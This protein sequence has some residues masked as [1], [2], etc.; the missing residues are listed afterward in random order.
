MDKPQNDG[1]SKRMGVERGQ[2]QYK[3][4]S[5]NAPARHNTSVLLLLALEAGY[6]HL[7]G[8]LGGCQIA[9]EHRA[10]EVRELLI[11]RESLEEL[12]PED[13]NG[14]YRRLNLAVRVPRDGEPKLSADVD[15]TFSKTAESY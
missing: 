15:L 2:K 6:E 8:L 11:A 4:R 1:R 12:S 14:L 3:G 7:L 13:R 10:E 5:P 9:L